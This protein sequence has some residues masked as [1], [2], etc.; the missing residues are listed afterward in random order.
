MVHIADTTESRSE[1]P[2][3]CVAV[4]SRR[5]PVLL[6]SCVIFLIHSAKKI[7]PEVVTSWANG[8]TGLNTSVAACQFINS[9]EYKSRIVFI[10]MNERV[11]REAVLLQHSRAGLSAKLFLICTTVLAHG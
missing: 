1:S 11:K 3:C 5:L 4:E 8:D 7:N 6:V 10:V 9:I 2:I